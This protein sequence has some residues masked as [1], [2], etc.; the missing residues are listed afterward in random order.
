VF[1]MSGLPGGLATRWEAAKRIL[2]EADGGMMHASI[3]RGTVR[4]VVP[5]DLPPEAIERLGAPGADWT[6]ILETAPAP[7]WTRLSPSAI[8]DRVSQSVRHAFDPL[9]ILNPGIL[10]T[11]N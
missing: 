8:S 5:R 9:A 2:E 6:L 7:L 4:C 11:V 1:R 3:G 10:G